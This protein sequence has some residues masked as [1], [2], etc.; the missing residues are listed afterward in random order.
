[1]LCKVQSMHFVQNQ[2]LT[3]AHSIYVPI[4]VPDPLSQKVRQRENKKGPVASKSGHKK[5]VN[6]MKAVVIYNV[7]YL[8][9][10]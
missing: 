7:K 3:K 2:T 4:S 9:F 1:M 6:L 8:C 10:L 5:T